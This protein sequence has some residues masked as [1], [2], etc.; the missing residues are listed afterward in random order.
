MTDDEDRIRRKAHELWEAE[1][2]P[3]GRDQEHW[4]QAKEIIAL[5]DSFGTTLR[6]LDETVS[7]PAEPAIAYEN[8][9]DVPG[10]T[11]LGEEGR[12]PSWEAARET[13]EEQA[14]TVDEQPA[15]TKAKKPAAAKAPKS[16][17]SPVTKKPA[18]P[19]AKK[20]AT[21]E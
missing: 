16:D 17:K 9:A 19:R 7:E 21:G 20:T 6:P 18:A 3:H 11:D 2:R 12:G 13:T 8:Q 15:K 1:G 5:Q 14:L 10:L 4:D